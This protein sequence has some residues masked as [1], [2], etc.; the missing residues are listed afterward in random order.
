MLLPPTLLLVL[1]SA[2]THAITGVGGGWSTA[3]AQQR[4]DGAT[5]LLP[6]HCTPGGAGGA[7]AAVSSMAGCGQ[8]GACVGGSCVCIGGYSGQRCQQPPTSMCALVRCGLGAAC[9]AGHCVRPDPCHGVECGSHGACTRGDCVCDVGFTGPACAT[10]DACASAPCQNGGSCYSGTDV[11][12][13]DGMANKQLQAAW[14]DRHICACVP[15]FTGVHCQCLECGTHG[16]C[17]SRGQCVC[18]AGFEGSRCEFDVE[19]KSAPC[20]NGGMRNGGTCSFVCTCKAGFEGETCKEESQLLVTAPLQPP[21]PDL[22]PF[23]KWGG[24]IDS[25]RPHNFAL[26]KS[27]YSQFTFKNA[28]RPGEL[29]EILDIDSD[30]QVAPEELAGLKAWVVD[31]GVRVPHSEL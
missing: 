24:Q 16:A 5:M 11:R 28:R 14:S 12:G 7:A 20:Q 17:S 22:R 8:H 26:F 10:A 30:G 3:A 23:I 4:R 25:D 19:C 21:G 31:T 6:A 27:K 18:D 15:G 29:F 9:K 1:A 2:I 13:G